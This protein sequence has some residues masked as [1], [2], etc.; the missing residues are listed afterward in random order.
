MTTT[1]YPGPLSIEG[2]KPPMTGPTPYIGGAAALGVPENPDFAPSL[3]WMGMGVRDPRYLQR[4]GGGA[5]VAGGYP[6]QDCG[7]YMSGPGIIAVD[8]VPAA[9]SATNIAGSQT[10]TSGGA[11]TLAG[12]STGI[13][14]L[15][16][17]LTILPTGNV[18]PAGALVID[19]NP[20]YTGGG[21]SGAFQFMNPTTAMSRALV[22]AVGNVTIHGNDIYGTPITQT[23]TAAT[24]TKAFKFVRSIVG[25]A[26]GSAVTVG[27]ADVFGLPIYSPAWPGTLVYWGT[28]PATLI[29]SPTG[30]VAGVTTTAS[31]TTGDTRG[32]YATQSSASDGTKRFTVFQPLPFGVIA[33][34]YAAA[35]AQLVGIPQF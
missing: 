18:I 15:A 26:S 19:G 9:A 14:V 8:Q 34:T 16:A 10:I 12:A 25:N 30:W 7:W 20:T 29:T 2:L 11:L 5:N 21:T 31:A 13:T 27:T 28:P 23:L 3:M 32:T 35:L 1:A 6:N 33:S 4:I 22:V 17:P 24:T